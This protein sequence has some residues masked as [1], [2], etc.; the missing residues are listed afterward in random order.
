MESVWTSIFTE[1]LGLVLLTIALAIASFPNVL[2]ILVRNL[3]VHPKLDLPRL[4]CVCVLNQLDQQY[5]FGMP[6][7][8]F[9][10]RKLAAWL[11]IA[12]FIVIFIANRIL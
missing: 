1:Q 9:L 3:E 6:L 4:C 8:K 11:A 2:R 12:G 5:I 7:G 10:D